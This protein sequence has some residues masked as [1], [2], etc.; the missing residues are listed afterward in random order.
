VKVTQQMITAFK[1]AVWVDLGGRVELMDTEIE[2]GI[3]AVLDLI[4]ADEATRNA[5]A[6][7]VLSAISAD[8][9]EGAH[10]AADGVLLNHVHPDVSAAWDALADRCGGFWYA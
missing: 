9:P 10:S 8:D 4:A 5:A 2:L 1:K 7:G 6:I 3:Q